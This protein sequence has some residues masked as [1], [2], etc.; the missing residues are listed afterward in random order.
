MSKFEGRTNN[1]G[2]KKDE[3]NLPVKK[4]GIIDSYFK[5]SDALKLPDISIQNFK[6]E[7][8]TSIDKKAPMFLWSKERLNNKIRLDN[9]KQ[10]LI[11]EKIQNLRAIGNE[12]TY[13]KAGAIFDEE[14][15][16]LLR[17]EEHTSEL[18]S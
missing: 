15:I 8:K 2:P 9:D 3:S 18:Q 14:Y 7:L 10:I 12:L 17:S 6:D 5:E 4:G 13:L 1:Y 11:L 16:R